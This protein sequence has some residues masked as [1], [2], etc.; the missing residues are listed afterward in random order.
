MKSGL[1]KS[2]KDLIV[3][4]K[5]L[6][7][8]FA[9]YKLTEQFPDTEKFGLI[10]Q[11]RRSAV[12]IPSNIAEGFRRG[13]RKEFNYFLSVAFSSGAELETQMEIAKS[14]SFGINSEHLKVNSLLEEVMK[15]LNILISKI[16]NSST[17]Y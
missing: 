13:G 8:V 14:L 11:M 9:V 17:T 7:L 1:I 6:Q 4:Q 10:S 12:S 15:M 3:W 16:S 5:A 2:Y